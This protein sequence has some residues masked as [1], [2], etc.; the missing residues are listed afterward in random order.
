MYF[1]SND[2]GEVDGGMDG[3]R[4]VK[5]WLLRVGDEYRDLPYYSAYFSVTVNSP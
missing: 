4:F 5:G 1:T 2:K 3:T